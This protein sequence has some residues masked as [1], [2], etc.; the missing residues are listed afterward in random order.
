MAPD[1]SVAQWRILCNDRDTNFDTYT[2]RLAELL[3]IIKFMNIESITSKA[4]EYGL[5]VRGAFAVSADDSVP[6][7]SDGAAARTLVLIGNTGSSVWPV[8]SQSMELQDGLDNPLDRWSVR[9]G[10][11]L[12]KELGAAAYYPFG[13]PPYQPFIHW[14]RKAES[15]R[16]SKIGLLLHPEFGLWHAYRLALAFP[17]TLF[18]EKNA[19]TEQAHAC[20][21]CKAQPC[22]GACPVGAF[23]DGHYDVDRCVSYLDANPQAECNKTGCLARMSCPEGAPFR[24][25]QAH[26]TFHMRQFV[27]ARTKTMKISND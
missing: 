23:S 16:S 19:A 15:L 12:A 4:I 8:F 25:E 20:D 22:H 14:A 5:V 27:I 1:R 10:D 11:A 18:D 6:S 26:A 3:A 13:G 21:T 7:M 24:Y 2:Q 9:V 17:D